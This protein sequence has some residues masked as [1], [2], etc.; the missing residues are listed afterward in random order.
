MSHNNGQNIISRLSDKLLLSIFQEHLAT[1][2]VL[3]C[4]RSCRRW[5]ALATTVLYRHL[6]LTNSDKLTSWAAAA[7]SSLDPMV[8]SLT[9]GITVVRTAAG[10][11]DPDTTMTQ[12]RQNLERLAARVRGMSKLASLS[13]T[14]PKKLTRG[15]WVPH[16][17]MTKVL[18]SVPSTC[19]SLELVIRNGPHQASAEEAECHLCVAIRRLMPQLQFVRLALPSVCPESFGQVSTDL[20]AFGAI[21]LPKLEEGIFILASPRMGNSVERFDVPCTANT[22]LAGMA[23]MVESLASLVEAGK[24]RAI[25]KLWVYDCLASPDGEGFS[26][27]AFVRRDIL[28]KKSLTFPW[29]DIAPL[30]RA[31]SFFIR[32]PAEEG[33]EDMITT[34]DNAAFLVERHAWKE[35]WNGARLSA[36]LMTE[37]GLVEHDCPVRTRERWF[38]DSGISTAL[39]KDEKDTGVRLL[40]GESGDLLED[41]PAGFRIPEGWERGFMGFV[42]RAG[43]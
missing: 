43:S 34:R 12:L 18:D 8:E 21:E 37:Y 31:D 22:S 17:D 10:P 38:A 7:P 24:A 35:A 29:T 40:D 15:L 39:W 26:Y 14:T 23:A 1:A 36:A 2:T 28:A 16:Q 9:V 13:V 6:T 5:H 30:K 41:R 3:A 33:G 11:Q 4:A 19:S 27:G 42:K 25:K 32:L 20:P